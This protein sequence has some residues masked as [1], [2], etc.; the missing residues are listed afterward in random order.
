[1]ADEKSV[2]VYAYVRGKRDG[3][4]YENDQAYLYRFDDDRK[5]IEVSVISVD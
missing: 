4:R 5:V 3:T 2:M 1:M